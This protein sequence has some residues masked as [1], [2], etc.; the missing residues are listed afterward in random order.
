MFS[1]FLEQMRIGKGFDGL[2]FV[3]FSSRRGGVIDFKCGVM[4]LLM[5]Y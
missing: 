5:A 4:L 1:F 3:G 2:V